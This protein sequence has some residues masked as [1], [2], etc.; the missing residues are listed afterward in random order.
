MNVLDDSI[1][2]HDDGHVIWLEI[3][4][5]DL[6]VLGVQCPNKDDPDSPCRLSR[7]QCLVEYFVMRFGLE[8]NVGVCEPTP[9]LQIAWSVNGDPHDIDACQ[10]WVIPVTDDVFSLWARTQRGETNEMDEDDAALS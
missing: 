4:R 10:C 8:C 6:A 7:I 5:S 9:E 1:V 2:W 3:N